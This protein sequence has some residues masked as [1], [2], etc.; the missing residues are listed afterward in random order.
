MN[1]I[2]ISFKN[3]FYDEEVKDIPML[4]N[5]ALHMDGND[6]RMLISGTATIELNADNTIKETN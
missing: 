4:L 2:L 5:V 1:P 3:P 6:K